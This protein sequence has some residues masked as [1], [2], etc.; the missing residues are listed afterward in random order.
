[1]T[2]DKFNLFLIAALCGIKA[3]FIEICDKHINK[4]CKAVVSAQN[5][6]CHQ[7]PPNL[8]RSNEFTQALL[9]GALGQQS[10]VILIC[11]AI[12]RYMCMLHPVSYH[13][14]SS[15][16]VSFGIMNGYTWFCTERP[17][18]LLNRLRACRLCNWPSAPSQRVAYTRNW[19]ALGSYKTMC[20]ANFTNAAINLE[21]S[22]TENN[23]FLLTCRFDFKI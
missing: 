10:A 18:T 3:T 4:R 15:K 17:D 11:M 8:H 1:M 7:T 13:K 5:V 9:R 23:Y 6:K 19:K 20:A 16:K 2:N 12:D 22:Q 14:H 21:R